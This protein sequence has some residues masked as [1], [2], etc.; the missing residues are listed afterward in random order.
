MASWKKGTM[1]QYDVYLGKWTRFCVEQKIHPIK[2]TIIQIMEFCTHLFENGL[3]YSTI[4]TAR[5][6]L[7]AYVQKIDGHTVGAHPDICRHLKGVG[8]LRP[9][10]A[11]Y[12]HAWDVD[13]VLSLLKKWHP[14]ETLTYKQ[15]AYKALM[16]LALTT[17][18]RLQTLHAFRV[19]MMTWTSDEVVLQVD[20]PLKHTREGQPLDRFRVYKYKDRRLCPYR[21]LKAYRDLTEP[22]RKPEM[23]HLWLSLSD[24][25]E[26]V[27]TNTLAR[28]LKDTMAEAGVDSKVFKAHS[29]RGASVSKADAMDLPTEVILKEGRWTNAVTF[30]RFYK[31]PI[32][33]DH[34]S[35]YQDTVLTMRR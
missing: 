9:P 16:L 10:K 14:L 1:K 25:K 6:S 22:L 31:R 34:D 15:L 29:T 35:T 23:N 30:A 18:Q 26:E 11:R 19:D 4:N 13:T 17:A 32:L 33:K 2:P 5:C 20:I 27:E 7:S 28:W 24:N 3:A 21:T 8:V 12:A